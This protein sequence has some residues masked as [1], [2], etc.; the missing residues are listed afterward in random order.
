MDLAAFDG[1]ELCC[2]HHSFYIITGIGHSQM[3]GCRQF[4]YTPLKT[5]TAVA[6]FLIRRME[7]VVE[8]IFSA[9]DRTDLPLRAP[10]R[11]DTT[12]LKRCYHT[13]PTKAQPGR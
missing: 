12:E 4:L 11:A 1:Y 2:C 9:E 3:I 5:P 6:D 13:A 7:N 10:Y 8:Q